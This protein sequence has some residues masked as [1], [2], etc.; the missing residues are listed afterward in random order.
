MVYEKAG[1]SRPVS[2]VL[3]S[4]KK[5][6]MTKYKVGSSESDIRSFIESEIG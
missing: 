2:G 4:L 5:N 3:E 6:K 1:L